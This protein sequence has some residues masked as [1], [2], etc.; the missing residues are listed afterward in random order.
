MSD[1]F[2]FSAGSWAS[3]IDNQSFG[4]EPDLLR[5]AFGSKFGVPTSAYGLDKIT[6]GK[7][8]GIDLLGVLGLGMGVAGN[9]FRGTRGQGPV[10]IDFFSKPTQLAGNRLGD[11]LKSDSNTSS[12]TPLI[13]A[14]FTRNIKSML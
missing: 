12:L 13:E 3:P 8:K 7:S 9:Y 11:Y 4:A 14:L 2:D 6:Q 1:G 5:T 10:N